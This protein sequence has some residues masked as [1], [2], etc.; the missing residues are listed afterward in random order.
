MPVAVAATPCKFSDVDLDDWVTG[1]STPPASLMMNQ[2]PPALPFHVAAASSMPPAPATAEDTAKENSDPNIQL[3][4]KRTLCFPNVPTGTHQKLGDVSVHCAE[5]PLRQG[6]DTV[7]HPPL[8]TAEDERPAA[9]TAVAIG[10]V[11]SVV[12][13]V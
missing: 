1:A 8:K 11:D 6:R 13:S 5:R 9:G 3:T 10:M 12:D 4:V 7:P 2:P